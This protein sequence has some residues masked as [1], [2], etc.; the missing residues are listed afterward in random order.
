M[1]GNDIIDLETA[2]RESNWKR[3]RFLDKI[4][5]PQ[6]QFL[7]LNSDV[8]EIMVW[9]LWSRKEAAY[10]IYNRDTNI[11]GYFPT[12]LIC[13]YESANLGTVSINNNLYHTKTIITKDCIHTVAVS[14]KENL[15]KIIKL[16]Y[17]TKIFKNQRLPYIIDTLT[18]NAIPISI[19]HH[20]RFIEA[21]RIKQ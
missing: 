3:N 8:P 4:F 16:D 1:I 15:T 9:N 20:G 17:N 14:Q 21:V 13:F 5:T 6:E 2:K 10:K 7:I 11:N 12:K 19:S 18:K